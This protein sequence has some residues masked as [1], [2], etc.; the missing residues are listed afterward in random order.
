[1]R[2]VPHGLNPMSSLYL[3][4]GCWYSNIDK[5]EGKGDGKEVGREAGTAVRG[6]DIDEKEPDMVRGE[7][8]RKVGR[9]GGG[10]V[11]FLSVR[12]RRGREGGEG[13]CSRGEAGTGGDVDEEEPDVVEVREGER[14]NETGVAVS[15]L[16]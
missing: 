13:G 9:G 3:L 15:R 11:P 1:M 2:A 5:E 6:G 8:E 16:Y 14:C 4:S 7:E 10:R 12:V